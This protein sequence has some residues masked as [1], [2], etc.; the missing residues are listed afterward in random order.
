MVTLR[1]RKAKIEAKIATNSNRKRVTK[2]KRKSAPTTK[3]I[4]KVKSKKEKVINKSIKNKAVD[5]SKIFEEFSKKTSLAKGSKKYQDAKW[6][7]DK[8]TSLAPDLEQEI[9]SKATLAYGA[10]DYQTKSKCTG[11]WSRMSIMVNKS[12]LSLMI[13]GQKNGNYVLESYNKSDLVNKKS[14][15]IGK[16]CIRFKVLEDLNLTNIEKVIKDGISADLSVYLV[17]K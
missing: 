16:S 11:R 3:P 10:F 12:G 17:N 14:V 2:V 8:I 1:P 9:Q 4:R 13:S 6:L 5:S 15:S 7:H